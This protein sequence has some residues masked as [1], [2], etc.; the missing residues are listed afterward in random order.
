MPINVKRT[1]PEII[2]NQPPRVRTFASFSY[3]KYDGHN[4]IVRFPIENNKQRHKIY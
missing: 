4:N 1:N 3:P 2:L